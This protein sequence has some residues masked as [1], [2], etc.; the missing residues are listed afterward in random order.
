[1]FCSGTAIQWFA[2][3][4]RLLLIRPHLKLY[5]ASEFSDI[6]PIFFFPQDEGK[7]EIQTHDLHFI[8]RGQYLIVLSLG[9]NNGHSSFVRFPFFFLSTLLLGFIFCQISFILH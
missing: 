8:K 1:M 2:K 7:G 6:V 3:L 5:L 4:T 9:L